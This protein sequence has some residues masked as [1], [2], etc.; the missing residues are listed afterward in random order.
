MNYSFKAANLKSFEYVKKSTTF[1]IASAPPIDKPFMGEDW[2]IKNEARINSNPI[3]KK[4][5]VSGYTIYKY[6]LTLEE[7]KIS[8]DPNIELGLHF[9]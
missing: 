5:F 2:W 4:R 7:Q 6:N 1:I 8:H 9:R 3:E